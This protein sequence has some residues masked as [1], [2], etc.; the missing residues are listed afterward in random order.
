MHDAKRVFK[1]IV[2]T[3]EQRILLEDEI[4]Q[5]VKDVKKTPYM[6]TRKPVLAMLVTFLLLI[7]GLGI[8]G[9]SFTY[10]GLWI[11]AAFL[12]LAAAM[13][14]MYIGISVPTDC[15]FSLSE[16]KINKMKFVMQFNEDVRE[17]VNNKLKNNGELIGRDYYYL[18]IEEQVKAATMPICRLKMKKIVE[19]TEEYQAN[20]LLKA[21]LNQSKVF[22]FTHRQEKQI[23]WKRSVRNNYIALAVLIVLVGTVVLNVNKSTPL[24][25]DKM[26]SS[27]LMGVILC[28]IYLGISFLGRVGDKYEDER[29]VLDPDLYDKLAH[30]TKYHQP[31]LDYVKKVYAEDRVLT[32]H[33]CYSLQLSQSIDAYN[34]HH[35]VKE[36]A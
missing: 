21:K 14:C 20:P 31:T 36:M 29:Y 19:N 15:E 16:D 12:V 17:Y 24:I 35:L 18:N 1:P 32:L 25:T 8:C 27:A 6:L 2:L 22:K 23:K 10:N 34:Y 7:I 30:I 33:D 28:L 3:E 11:I 5:K 9:L 13:G 26:A 4:R